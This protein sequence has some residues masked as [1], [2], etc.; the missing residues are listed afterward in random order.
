MASIIHEKTNSMILILQICSQVKWKCT[1]PC[2]IIHQGENMDTIINFLISVNKKWFSRCLYIVLPLFALIMNIVYVR[3]M[4]IKREILHDITLLLVIAY[5]V[6]IPGMTLY[7]INRYRS[8]S[9][10][11]LNCMMAIAGFFLSSI[12]NFI[13]TRVHPFIVILSIILMLIL[14]AIAVLVSFSSRRYD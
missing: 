13:S 1:P 11:D 14:T 2:A 9:K 8:S 3:D 6:I 12:L 10:K 4:I 5:I 7:A